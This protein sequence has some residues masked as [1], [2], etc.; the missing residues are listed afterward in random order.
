MLLVLT[1]SRC[2][3]RPSKGEAHFTHDPRMAERLRTDAVSPLPP[4]ADVRRV[5]L[6]AMTLDEQNALAEYFHGQGYWVCWCD[7]QNDYDRSTLPPVARSR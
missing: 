5:A 3:W 2:R 7:G 6:G 1:P 4:D